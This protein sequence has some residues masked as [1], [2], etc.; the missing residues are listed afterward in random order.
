MSLLTDEEK[1][2]LSIRRMIFHVVGKTLE[3][4]ILLQEI[5]P[6]EHAD[7]FLKRVESVLRG[8]LFEFKPYSN[9]ERILRLVAKDGDD[10][11]EHTQELAR[12]FQRQHHS[13]T[14]SMGV[15]FV[16]EM[17]LGDGKTIYALIKYD[18]EDVVRYVL[19]NTGK[20]QVPRLERFCESFV[21]KA[22]AMQKIALVRLAE[23]QGGKVVVRDRSEPAHIS[24][25]FE[26]FLQVR[27]INSPADMSG[28]LV[29]A[30]KQT[31]KDHR[32]SLPPDIQK[33]GVNRIY[34]VMRQGGHRFDPENPE[35][36][37]T[38][39]F[40]QVA[41]DS[42]LR[43]TLTRLLKEK[44]IANET[45]DIDPKS[46]Q[47]PTRC[48]M[49]TAEGTQIIYDEGHKPL[50]RPHADGKRIEIVIVT[51]QVIEDDVDIENNPR[52]N[53]S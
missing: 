33:G 23:D 15:F 22:E 26:A 3:E 44:G 39:I 48:R 31:F 50:Q 29:E 16:F 53:R 42:P 43:K 18:N 5:S 11:T 4:P 8:N 25:Y 41:D 13:R 28:K 34:E 36:I 24:D 47:K 51:T 45:F 27:R 6:P 37:I 17:G 52:S 9:V 40:G 14:M 10:F 20:P 49:K 2:S 46:V 38:S 7:F 32:T 12:D 21:R 35:P 30:F 1:E 19:D